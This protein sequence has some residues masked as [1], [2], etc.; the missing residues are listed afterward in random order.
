MALTIYH[1]N[2]CSKSRAA[3]AL[4]ERQGQPFEV[5]NYLEQPP[6]VAQLRQLLGKLGLQA[7]ELV[8]RDEPDFRTLGLADADEQTLLEAMSQHPRLIQ[9]PIVVRDQRAVLGRP[10]ENVLALF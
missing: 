3:L 7:Q 4:L 9:R 5:V 1:N 10:P 8:R 6:S 2:R